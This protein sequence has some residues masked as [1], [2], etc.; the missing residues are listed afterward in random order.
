M[1]KK[2]SAVGIIVQSGNVL[3]LKRHPYDRTLPNVYCLPGGK[4]E[5]SEGELQ[6][7]VREVYEETGINIDLQTTSKY[8]SK[9][10]DKFDIHFFITIPDNFEVT[11]SDEHASYKWIPLSEL[12]MHKDSIAPLTLQVLTTLPQTTCYYHR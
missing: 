9:S 8:T 5:E 6:A 11:L 10:N 4:V 2:Q 7:L 12:E 3:L 1:S